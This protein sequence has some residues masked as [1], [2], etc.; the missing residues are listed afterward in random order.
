M[1][2]IGFNKKSLTK[3][4][5]ENF[6]KNYEELDYIEPLGGNITVLIAKN[7]SN[8]EAVS[9]TDLGTVQI[10]RAIRDEGKILTNRL[11]KTKYSSIVYARALKRS[12]EPFDDYLDQA[13][14]EF[15][16]RNM[17]KNEKFSEDGENSWSTYL[18]LLPSLAKR[19]AEINI[20]KEPAFQII[21]AFDD[22]KTLCYCDSARFENDNDDHTDDHI[23]LAETMLNFNGKAIVSGVLSPL[24]KR[25]YKTWKCV[26]KPQSNQKSKIDCVWVNF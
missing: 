3:W 12:K 10:I 1:T 17:G 9:D 20:F 25:L 16:I 15:V 14:N 21:K 18:E 11:K 24:Y 2:K 4:I 7:K 26:K 22:E 8:L 6:P 19:I 23:K 5:I 13:I